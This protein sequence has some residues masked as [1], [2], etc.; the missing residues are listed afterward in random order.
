MSREFVWK[1]EKQPR[2]LLFDKI[3]KDK[4]HGIAPQKTDQ[5]WLVSV[6][7]DDWHDIAVI[8]E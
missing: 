1:G 5:G 3:G 6:K 8:E 2:V 7:L 4:P